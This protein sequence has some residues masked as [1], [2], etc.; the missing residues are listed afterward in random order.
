MSA[1]ENISDLT[2]GFYSVSVVDATDCVFGDMYEVPE[3]DTLIVA[4]GTS[5]DLS[6]FDS[7]D[8][9]IFLDVTGG[10]IDYEFAWTGPDNF[11]SDEEDPSDLSI[12]TY[13]VLVTDANSCT[14]TFDVDVDGPEEISILETIQEPLCFGIDNGT[15]S[16][17]A[18]G[19]ASGFTYAWTGPNGFNSVQQ[20]VVSLVSGTYTI[21][22]TDVND[23]EA[24]E[25]Y[26]LT[27]EQV[28]DNALDF[29]AISC[30]GDADGFIDTDVSGGTPDYQYS[31]SG[32]NS[33]VSIDPNISGLAGGEYIMTTTDDMGCLRM[34]TVVITEPGLLEVASFS[35]VNQSCF[36]EAEG[37]IDINVGGGTADFNFAWSGPNGFTSSQEDISNISA[38]SYM[39]QIVDENNCEADETFI[40][41]E[42]VAI[43]V[44]LDGS[45]DAQCGS[46]PDGALDVSA[47]G[48]DPGYTFLWTGPNGFTAMTEDITGLFPGIYTVLVTDEMDCTM[49]EAFS[50]GAVLD[51][52]ADA[53]QAD[54]VCEGT[55]VT[56]NASNSVSA[57]N[58]IWTN[59][60]GDT[61]STDIVFSAQVQSGTNVY[62][63]TASDGIC[64]DTDTIVVELYPN[65]LPDAGVDITAFFEETVELGGDPTFSGIANYSWQPSGLLE[66]PSLANPD[67]QVTQTTN[68]IVTVTDVNG[69]TGT[70][71]IIVN[72]IPNLVVPD[73]FSPNG[74]DANDF[75]VLGNSNR[76]P[77]MTVEIFNR[78]GDK[79]FSSGGENFF[80]DGKFEDVDVPVGTYYY[81][82]ELN[83]PLF[84]DPITGPLTIF[85]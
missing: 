70:D 32:P 58:Y 55:L 79:V 67:Y 44:I 31:W 74:D 72:M 26:T 7:E 18:A 51:L 50:I 80:W 21:T 78:W 33:F 69:C 25:S 23:C 59:L 9:Q 83:D 35:Q 22:V 66:S 62:A 19:G 34:D 16:V 27:G 71:D 52:N 14:A 13:S 28:L 17:N 60:A 77:S 53:G 61:V 15:I 5:Q 20:S 85:R 29:N 73:G 68:F 8:G 2:P 43:D 4:T 81:A 11:N 12:G 6:C 36:G 10:T 24:S 76:F 63:L 42:P 65:P 39:V 47:Q 75:W 45:I 41:T 38:G 1:M 64:T 84:P 46:S 37:G 49:D 57:N 54:P 30:F 56:F 40:I 82:I 48:G 3:P